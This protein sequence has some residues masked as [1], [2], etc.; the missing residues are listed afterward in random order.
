[1]GAR[2][3]LYGLD[4]V[5][6][7]AA[8]MVFA[9]HG[10]GW[11][12]FNL[13]VDVFFVLS[14]FVI[15]R[16]YEARLRDGLGAVRF[17]A[18]RYR[19]LWLLPFIGS[20]LGLALYWQRVGFQPEMLA[21]LALIALFLPSRIANLNA[22]AL[23]FPIWSMFV[24]LVCNALH[25]LLLARASTAALMSVFAASGAVF[26]V[27]VFSFGFAPDGYTMTTTVLA[28][29]RGLTSY[30]LGVLI[31]RLWQ[32]A[33]LGRAPHLAVLALPLAVAA[34]HLLPK[35]V[36]VMATVL[37]V[38]P[39]VLRASLALGEAKWAQWLGAL[40]FPLYAV[41]MP[42]LQI[43]FNRDLPVAPFMVLALL[44]AIGLTVT[45]ERARPGLL[46]ARPS[47]S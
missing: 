33:P 13:G 10:L 34:L 36:A 40:S 4:A 39:L 35:P 22:F 19:R 30:T 2:D 43:A 44:V 45:V 20:A 18:L 9:C 32:D 46:T 11:S 17:V 8:L 26:A 16:T 47:L 21:S 31:Y 5:R 12:A 3:R 6:G 38:A 15:A 42:I 23:N 28:I 25:A 41:H 14:G 24:E 27:S 29:A 7:V 1:M 37:V